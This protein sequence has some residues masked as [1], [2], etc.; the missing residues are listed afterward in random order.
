MSNEEFC[1]T[2][3]RKYIEIENIEDKAENIILQEELKNN[4]HKIE[5]ELTSEK[6]FID[7]VEEKA[8]NKLRQKYPDILFENN[9]ISI[10]KRKKFTA[11]KIVLTVTIE[12]RK[13]TLSSFMSKYFKKKGLKVLILEEISLKIKEDLDLFY[14]IIDTYKKMMKSIDSATDD[15]DIIIFNR[16]YLNTEVFNNI[17]SDDDLKSFYLKTKCEMIDLCNFKY[18][19]YIKSTE[20]TSIKRQRERNREGETYTEEYMRKVYREYERI[21]SKMYSKHIVFD[22]EEDVYLKDKDEYVLDKD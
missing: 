7:L 4:Y 1:K 19:F 2:K 17:N 14:L 16:T 6:W 18:V 3:K 20:N 13:T 10:K 11:K 9:R 5:Q 22:T 15:Y 8:R 12:A 21:I